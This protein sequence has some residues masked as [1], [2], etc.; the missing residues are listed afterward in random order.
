MQERMNWK[1]EERVEELQGKMMKDWI[2]LEFSATNVN[3]LGLFPKLTH[4][5]VVNDCEPFAVVSS[6]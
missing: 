6:I 4:W 1:V 2:I 3:V 5:L